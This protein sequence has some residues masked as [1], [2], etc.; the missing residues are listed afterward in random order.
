MEDNGY[1]T[2]DCSLFN[3][4]SGLGSLTCTYPEGFCSPQYPSVCGSTFQMVTVT[5]SSIA[6]YYQCLYPDDAVPMESFCGSFT[7]DYELDTRLPVECEFK[8]NNV[9]CNS[10]LPVDGC[11]RNS[12]TIG[13]GSTFDCTNTVVNIE[14]NTCETGLFGAFFYAP[15]ETPSPSSM[16]I[17]PTPSTAPLET[18]SI[19]PVAMPTP[20]T[21]SGSSHKTEVAIV[22]SAAGTA[23]LASFGT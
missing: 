6:Y 4:T 19:S 5:N 20:T 11:P 9:T 7:S 15:L 10:C 17:M 13:F 3:N 14:G 23:W 22:A 18:P 21:S 12:T 2:C 1:S 16:E 8:I